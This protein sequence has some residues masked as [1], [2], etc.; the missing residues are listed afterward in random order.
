MIPNFAQRS[1]VKVFNNSF[2]VQQKKNLTVR[3]LVAS[4]GSWSSELLRLTTSR[5]SDEER[6]VV[7]SEDILQFSLALLI[8]VLVI[9]GNQSLGEGLTNS[10][11]LGDM[12]SSTD[13]DS[14]VNVLEAFLSDEKKWLLE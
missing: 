14:D 7:G 8:D 11:D 10:V 12:S 6:L 4:T 13:A 2:I 5:V 1:P 3:L 9:V